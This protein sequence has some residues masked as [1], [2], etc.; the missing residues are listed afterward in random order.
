MCW[1]RHFPICFSLSLLRGSLRAVHLTAGKVSAESPPAGHRQHVLQT[2]S[3]SPRT[4]APRQ[5]CFNSR[6]TL[7]RN[8]KWW[9][10]EQGR[11][12]SSPWSTVPLLL[13]VAAALYS[14]AQ[15]FPARMGSY[16]RTVPPIHP[17]VSHFQPPCAHSRSA[18]PCSCADG[19]MTASELYFAK[20][21]GLRGDLLSS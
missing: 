21:C 17:K 4:H 1:K 20:D 7:T 6:L 9:S 3:Q 19:A 18:F 12:T 15:P 11:L 8:I 10:E 14:Q 5:F 2:M 16:S 13:S